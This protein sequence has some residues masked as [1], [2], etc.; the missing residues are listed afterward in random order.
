VPI[1]SSLFPFFFHL[2]LSTLGQRQPTHLQVPLVLV[3]L[4]TNSQFVL[5]VTPS[6]AKMTRP[7]THFPIPPYFTNAIQTRT[8]FVGISRVCKP[9]LLLVEEGVA[10]EYQCVRLLAFPLS[11][12]ALS[13]LDSG[14]RH[15]RCF[16]GFPL[17]G[18]H[19]FY[20]RIWL[21]PLRSARGQPLHE[22]NTDLCSFFFAIQQNFSY[23][24]SPK[25]RLHPRVLQRNR[26]TIRSTG[27]GPTLFA[28]YQRKLKVYI[29]HAL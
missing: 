23:G 29:N 8:P 13:R 19:P 27:D 16:H 9:A 11:L 2:S 3:W 5:C 6:Y 7:S 18:R 15:R 24:D 4:R 26:G 21:T 14:P 28:V 25:P 10:L 12:C 22:D 20:R 1:L 17:P